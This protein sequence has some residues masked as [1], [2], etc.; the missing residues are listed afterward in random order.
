MKKVA[1]T[2]LV[3]CVVVLCY[4]FGKPPVR[5]YSFSGAPKNRAQLGEVLFFETKLSADGSI[6]CGSC[7]I[8]EFA[9]ADTV[10][11]SRGVGNKPGRRNAPSCA[12]MADRAHLFYDGRAATLE[13]QV[14]F[15]VEDKNEMSASL[16]VAVKRLTQDKQYVAWFKNIYHSAPTEAAIKSAIAEFERTLETGES[17]FDHYMDDKNAGHISASAIRG[18]ELFLEKARCFEC[19][20]SPDFTGDEFRNIGLFDGKSLNDSGRYEVT[21]DPKDIGKFKVPGLRNV[22]ITAPYMHNGMF[23]T[24]KEVIEFYSDPYKVVP[25]PLYIDSVMAVP[26]NL[27][28]T[29]KADLEA[30]LITLTDERFKRK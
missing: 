28:E 14:R 21:K 10:A 24:L 19:H 17:P 27:N 9:F 1:I 2:G 16:A 13:E 7:H 15:P 22:A 11:F 18:R 6:S 8:P 4:S 26:L 25:N 12:N 30:F 5:K 23:K 29:E 3:C 20:Y